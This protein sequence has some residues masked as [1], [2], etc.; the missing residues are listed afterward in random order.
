MKIS[1]L[2][3]KWNLKFVN[4]LANNYGICDHPEEKNKTIKIQKGLNEE[5]ELGTIIHECLHA[6]DWSKDEEWV[7]QVS[8]DI[9]K[10]LLKMGYRK[11][12]DDVV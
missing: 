8:R 10:I 4:N 11:K 9:C 5:D 1:I 3:K 7:D 12:K 6:S 2:G